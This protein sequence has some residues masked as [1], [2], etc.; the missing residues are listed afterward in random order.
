MLRDRLKALF[1]SCDPTVKRVIHETLDLEQQYISMKLPRGVM[2][3]IDALIS[4]L[5]KQ[6]LVNRRDEVNQE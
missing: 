6:E 2:E 5:A 4:K 3:D 1:D